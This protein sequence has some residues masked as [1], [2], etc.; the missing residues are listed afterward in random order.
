MALVGSITV[1]L[2]LVGCAMEVENTRPARAIAAPAKPVYSLYAGWRV[3]Q[4]KCALCHSALATGSEHAPDLLPLVRDM[5]ERQFTA[6]VLKRYDL[7]NL[8]A[9][10]AEQATADTR[11]DAILQRRD[12][13]I[14]MPAWQSDVAVNA[15]IADLYAYLS[16]RAEGKID[17]NRPPE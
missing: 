16:A 4:D 8:G 13:P 9:M 10:D 1:S 11:I 15:H 6:L 17:E 3:F 7:D 2:I 12:S 5:T 14:Q